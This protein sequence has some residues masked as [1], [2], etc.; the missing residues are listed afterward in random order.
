MAFAALARAG[1]ARARAA[2]C[3]ARWPRAAARAASGFDEAGEADYV[4][5][6]AGSAGCVLAHRL[7]ASG[8]HSVVL[9]EAGGESAAA[10]PALGA[11]PHADRA[12]APD[13]PRR[14]EQRGG[15]RAA[16]L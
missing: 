7:S 9:L 14:E 12:R 1:A 2:R 10:R 6:G 8:A 4:I 11:E 13:A 5:V 15:A 16:R 3:P